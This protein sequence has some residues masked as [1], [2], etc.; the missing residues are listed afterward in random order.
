MMQHQKHE[1]AKCYNKS[2]KDLPSLKTGDVV[3]V[4]LVPNMRKW[5][6]GIVIERVSAQD[7]TK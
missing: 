1:Q 2:A 4:Q 3:Y 5:I 7:H 6:P